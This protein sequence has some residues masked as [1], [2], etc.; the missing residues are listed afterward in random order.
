M[1]APDDRVQARVRQVVAQVSDARLD[2]IGGVAVEG[3]QAASLFR[4]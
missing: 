1:H 2:F 3:V 4:V